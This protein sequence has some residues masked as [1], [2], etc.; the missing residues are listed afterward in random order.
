MSKNY[1]IFMA[2]VLISAPLLS[3]PIVKPPA[4]RWGG[5]WSTHKFLIMILYK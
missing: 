3:V 5:F 4:S 1:L 2:S